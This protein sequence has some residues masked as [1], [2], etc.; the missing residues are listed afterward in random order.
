MTTLND[1]QRRYADLIARFG[2]NVQPGQ[3]VLISAEIVGRDFVDLVLQACYQAG[4][5]YVQIGWVDPKTQHSRVM[6][7]SEASI[8]YIPDYEVARHNQMADERWARIAITGEEFPDINNDLDPKRLGRMRSA[9]AQKFRRYIDAQMSNQMQWTVVAMPTENWARKV[10]PDLPVDQAVNRLWEIVLRAV[11]VDADDPVA[12]WRAHERTLKQ[13]AEY[14]A[15]HAV[16]A[17]RYFDPNPAAD[18]KPSTDL[19]VGLTDAP[20][21]VGGGA[22]TPAGVPFMA[23]MP[24][25]EVFCTPHNQKAE[26][27]VRTSKPL[28]PLGRE[29]NDA[30]FRFE[31]GLCVEARAAKGEDV[32]NSFLEIKGARRLGEVSLVDVR[33]PINQEGVVFYDTLFDENAA[34][35]IAF[36]KAYSECVAGADAMTPEQQEA[37]G[38]NHSD[39]HEDFMIGTPTMRVTGICADGRVI[40]V[41]REGK[42]VDAIYTADAS[43]TPNPVAR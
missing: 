16:R 25:E 15:K 37:F 21:W 20:L 12:T 3:N 31:N 17:I 1:L 7:S 10:F 23:N 11:R 13:V 34:C 22:E 42:F 19:T 29:V 5:G 18:G 30:Y 8:D 32:L 2:A 41:M 28:F 36:G 43:A 39:A 26:G 33:S 6:L 14:M 27:W 4:A 38:M 40:D 24:T 35:H 9:R